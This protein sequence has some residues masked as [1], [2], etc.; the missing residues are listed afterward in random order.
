MAFALPTRS[1]HSTAAPIGATR[2]APVLVF[3][4][5]ASP[6][7][8]LYHVSWHRGKGVRARPLIC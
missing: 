8:T 3:Q 7:F 6:H 4:M 2:Q 5:P 1:V